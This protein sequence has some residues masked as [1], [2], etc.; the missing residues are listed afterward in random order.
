MELDK[1]V[2][3]GHLLLE[4]RVCRVCG[5]EKNLVDEYYLSRKNPALA[6]SY[7]YECKECTVKRTVEYNKEHSSSVKSQYLKRNYGLTFE[8]FESMLSDQNNCCAICGTTE[9]SK[10]RGRHKRFHVDHDSSGKVR[11]LLCKSCNIA[12]GEVGDSI[13]TLK[14]M[15]K[16][17]EKDHETN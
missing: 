1:Q 9:P 12:L 15:I 5:K 3:T 6:S 4:T 16:Y 2:T 13:H 17:L 11:G 14:S 10:T 7:S 8:E